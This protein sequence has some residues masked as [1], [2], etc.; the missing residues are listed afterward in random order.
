MVALVAAWQ[1]LSS[2]WHPETTAHLEPATPSAGEQL[3]TVPKHTMHRCGTAST[4]SSG[5]ICDCQSDNV[6]TILLVATT[7]SQTEL[8]SSVET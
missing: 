5:G 6:D 3:A 7:L 1:R 2:T 8:G 4:P